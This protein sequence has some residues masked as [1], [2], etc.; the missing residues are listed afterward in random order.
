MRLWLAFRAFFAALFSAEAAKQIQQ[1][2]V[3]GSPGQP[4]AIEH[5]KPAAPERPSPPRPARSEALTLLSTLQREA[6]FIDFVQESLDDYTDAQIGAAARD[7]HR[8]CGKLLERMFQICP[9][10]DGQEGASL[11]VPG[12]FDAGQYHLTGN[13]TGEP[14]FQGRLTHHG[15]QASRCDLPTWSGGDK[16]ALVI[17][18]AEV[19]V[20]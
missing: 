9:L 6:R 11:E 1:I 16:S 20:G 19:E 3:A 7:V 8:E 17:A 10:L 13:V 15:W 4:E 2:F 18:P 14:P 5:K 12:G